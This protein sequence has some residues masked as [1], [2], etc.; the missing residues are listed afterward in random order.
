MRLLSV[1]LSLLLFFIPTT[2]L[3]AQA[4]PQT[5]IF[6]VENRLG[7]RVGV[8]ALDTGTER[9]IEYRANERFP[10][11]STVK[12]LAAADVLCR[13]PTPTL[14]QTIALTARDLLPHSPD[15][16]EHLKKGGMKL[17]ELCAASVKHSDNTAGNLLLHFLGGPL[18][19]TAFCRSLGDGQ[20]RLDRYEPSLNTALPGDPRDTTTPQAM[21]DDLRTLFLGTA[22]SAQSR[23]QLETWMRG[24]TTGLNRIRAGVPPGWLV[25]DK[26]GTGHN[27]AAGDIAIVRLPDR[28]LILMAIYLFGSRADP[29]RLNA[30]IAELA[31]I[32]ASNI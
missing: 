31:R 16:S 30:A 26:T 25:G 19:F 29:E 28:A 2:F 22:L 1:D 10:L 15:A 24:C 5:R 18:K 20:T 27:G 21:V 6:S 4:D 23:D 13:A 9:K 17:R 12:F 3:L 14:D 32:V 8:A 7:G 11:C